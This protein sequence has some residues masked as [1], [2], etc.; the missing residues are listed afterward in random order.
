LCFLNVWLT[1]RIQTLGLL[2]SNGKDSYLNLR[3]REREWKER[4][5]KKRRERELFKSKEYL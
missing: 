3:L 2:T 4:V 5:I 1:F